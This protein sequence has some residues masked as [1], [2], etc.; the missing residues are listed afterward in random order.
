MIQLIEVSSGE[1][2]HAE[3]TRGSSGKVT[4]DFTTNP[5]TNAIRILINKIG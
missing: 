1:T 5:G 3:V 2:V 4:V